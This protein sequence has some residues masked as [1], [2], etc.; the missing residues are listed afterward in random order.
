VP[1]TTR[2]RA[3][4]PQQAQVGIFGGIWRRVVIVATAVVA[5]I[6]VVVGANL[7]GSGGGP[8]PTQV[9]VVSPGQSAGPSGASP[10]ASAS[11]PSPSTSASSGPALA[12]GSGELIGELISDGILSDADAAAAATVDDPDGDLAYTD[13]SATTTVTDPAADFTDIAIASSDLD[14]AQVDLLES[15][16][17]CGQGATDGELVVC[18][19]TPLAMS[20]GPIVFVAFGLAGPPPFSYDTNQWLY[21][22]VVTDA[23]GNVL[24]NDLPRAPILAHPGIGTDRWIQLGHIQ[25]RFTGAATDLLGPPGQSGSRQFNDTT[26][27]RLVLSQMPA[28]GIMF[29][30]ADELGEGVRLNSTRITGSPI[31]PQTA[32]SDWMSGPG[33]AFDF[34]PLVGPVMP[35]EPS[36]SNGC[37]NVTHQPLSRPPRTFPSFTTQTYVV[38]PGFEIPPGSTIDLTLDEEGSELVQT[39]VPLELG[40]GPEGLTTV[41][42]TFGITR[43]GPKRIVRVVLNPPGGSPIDIT[44]PIH[45]LFGPGFVVTPQEGPVAGLN[46]P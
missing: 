30:P 24:N 11:G 17:P 1:S 29:G 14:Q 43:Y 35:S 37:T 25:D 7:L 16:F 32:A 42:A 40:D 12:G 8:G 36:L 28:G 15:R 20:P 44:E 22:N 2:L 27:W 9:A 23:D 18:S 6:A 26:A 31:S 46:C 45:D 13:P 19:T 38:P 21:F 4:Q 39:G 10:S 41:S 34:L 33:G 5:V 3:P